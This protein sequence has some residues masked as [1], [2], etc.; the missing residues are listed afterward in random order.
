MSAQEETLEHRVI[1]LKQIQR[2]MGVVTWIRA[3]QLEACAQGR[4]TVTLIIEG[5]DVKAAQ[6]DVLQAQ[7]VF[8]ACAR[9]VGQLEADI[10]KREKS[11]GH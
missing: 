9:S 5:L 4:S 7:E 2:L 3:E 6:T 10:V 11:N 8:K 1:Q